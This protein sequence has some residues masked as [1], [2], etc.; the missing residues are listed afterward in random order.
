M[1]G[2][3]AR[4]HTRRIAYDPR[5]SEENGAYL[6]GSRAEPTGRQRKSYGGLKYAAY[7]VT[8]GSSGGHDSLG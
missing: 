7:E 6:M 2:D 8:T 3:T 5:Y 4:E 1:S